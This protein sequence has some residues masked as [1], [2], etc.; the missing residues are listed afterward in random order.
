MTDGR[1]NPL[2][3]T[4][5]TVP[6]TGRVPHNVSPE[7]KRYLEAVQQC[8]EIR[9]GRRGDARDRAVTLR[10][11][12]DSG[13]AKQL[14]AKPYDPNSSDGPDFETPTIP[15]AET[16]TK[17][18]ITATGTFGSIKITWT[19]PMDYIGHSYTQIH[20]GTTTTRGEA[21][22]IGRSDGSMF[23]DVTPSAGTTYYY[24]ARHVSLSGELGPWSNMASASI[25]TDVNFLIQTL[26]SAI[27]QSELATALSTKIDQIDV[28]AVSVKKGEQQYTVKIGT[29]VDSNGNPFPISNAPTT[30]TS[31]TP[32]NGSEVLTV[33]F[34]SITNS[35][36][37]IGDILHITACTALG[38]NITQAVLQQRYAVTTINY[39]ASTLTITARTAGTDIGA[40]AAV[41]ANASDNTVNSGTRTC[42]FYGTY[43]SGFG[44]SNSSTEAGT[45]QSNF[46]VAADNFAVISP[47]GYNGVQQLAAA[48][49]NVP[50]AV[51][52]NASFVDG[53][54]IPAGVYIQD[55]FINKARIL[56]LIAGSVRAD[57]IASNQLMSAPHLEAMTI[58]LGQL[59]KNSTTSNTSNISLTTAAGTEVTFTLVSAPS[60]AYSLGDTLRCVRV[61]NTDHYIEIRTTL[62]SGTTLKGT[63]VSS[64]G[65]GTPSGTPAWTIEHGNPGKWTLTNAGTRYTHFS[66]DAAGVMYAAYGQLK[67]M[68]VLAPD[69]TVLMRSGGPSVGAGGNL[70]DNGDFI[71]EPNSSGGVTGG[72]GW[73]T[74]GTVSFNVTAATVTINTSGYITS[75]SYFPMTAGENLFVQVEGT[76]LSSSNTTVTILGYNSTSSSNFAKDYKSSTSASGG[77]WDVSGDNGAVYAKIT[78]PS[79]ADGISFGKVRLSAPSGNITY[80][81]I[82]VGRAPKTISGNYASTYIRNAAVDTLQLAGQAVTIP[83]TDFTEAGQDIGNSSYTDLATLTYTSTG[84]DVT[85]SASAFFQ[86]F[87]TDQGASYYFRLIRVIS[88]TTLELTEQKLQLG[89]VD[90][91]QDVV[92]DAGAGTMGSMVFL[93]QTTTTGSRTYKIQAKRHS[94]NGTITA[95]NRSLTAI[96]VKR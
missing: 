43:V 73:T 5:T 81:N 29:A 91:A 94:G 71:A 41:L 67:G 70:L 80:K 69:G 92:G 2:K 24:W 32:T 9:M 30:F 62:L 27:T 20:R 51:T 18:T 1:R 50:F 95:Y 89:A 31:V 42:V 90:I 88:S 4:P 68:S 78:A 60:V 65:S 38:G 57:F 21:G 63:I 79:H 87:T 53:V 11:L 16:P 74:S 26:S 52:T 47:T 23:V 44:L 19:F 36:I 40:G 7:L 72:Q 93:D 39:S 66:V 61:S 56:D 13:L 33:A 84:N 83:S 48:N 86:N 34:S 77:N 75:E 82:W 22:F 45:V 54:E 10:E 14:K 55:A 17:P 76:S 96:E 35:M 59:D 6:D 12:I 15:T 8:V 37:G 64:N 58:N 46:I 25:L 3:A 85:I 28:N 49:R